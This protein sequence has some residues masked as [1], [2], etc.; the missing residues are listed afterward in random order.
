M[1]ELAIANMQWGT[2][3]TTPVASQEALI[4][5][6]GLKK[7][8]EVEYPGPT[9]VRFTS[10]LDY[11]DLNGESLREVV[12]LTHSGLVFARKTFVPEEEKAYAFLWTFIWT[13]N[14]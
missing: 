14:F 12:L 10:V 2:D 5:P 1:P 11:G 6:L 7:P 13:I 9:S 8:V 4:A 3:S